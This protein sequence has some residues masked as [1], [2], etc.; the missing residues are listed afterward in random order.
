MIM[1]RRHFRLLV[2]DAAIRYPMLA[3]I[4]VPRTC[5]SRKIWGNCTEF[6]MMIVFE[7]KEYNIARVTSVQ[8]KIV[9]EIT[10]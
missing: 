4:D 2:H 9:N 6:D 10:Q 5:G 3:E 7:I 8:Q 1:R